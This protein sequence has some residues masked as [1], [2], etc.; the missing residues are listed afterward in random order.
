[1][2]KNLVFGFTRYMINKYIYIIYIYIFFTGR[3]MG[4]NGSL[5]RGINVHPFSLYTR[6]LAANQPAQQDH[7][8]HGIQLSQNRV[9]SN[10]QKDRKVNDHYLSRKL[11]V[12]SIFEDCLY[13]YNPRVTPLYERLYIQG[14]FH[15]SRGQVAKRMLGTG[16]S[17]V[18]FWSVGRSKPKQVLEG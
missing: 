2:E 9:C 5:L 16:A 4:W 3:G 1:M 7:V 18:E 6:S 12:V 11:L 13:P 10:H 8:F 14:L 15:V 17:R